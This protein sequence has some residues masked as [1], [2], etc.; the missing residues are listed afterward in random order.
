MW[1]PYPGV[2]YSIQMANIVTLTGGRD[3]GSADGS[4][5]RGRNTCLAPGAGNPRYAT[6]SMCS[7]SLFWRICTSVKGGGEREQS[8]KEVN[9][10]M[11]WGRTEELGLQQQWQNRSQ[12]IGQQLFLTCSYQGAYLTEL[13]V[14]PCSCTHRDTPWINPVLLI[15]LL[16]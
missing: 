3:S 1:A 6:V 11:T 12:N 10:W 9:G 14:P 2:H 8:Q 5:I 4:R 16:I 13:S 15:R 7:S